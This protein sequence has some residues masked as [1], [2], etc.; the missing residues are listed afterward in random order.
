[1]IDGN[2]S[3]KAGTGSRIGQKH[4][5]ISTTGADCL[6]RFRPVVKMAGTAGAGHCPPIC[7]QYCRVNT[8][9][10]CSRHQANY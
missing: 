5:R 8:I 6:P 1:M 10:T 3:I 9:G 2:R 7:Q 4:R